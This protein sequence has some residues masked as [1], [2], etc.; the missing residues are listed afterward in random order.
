VAYFIFFERD[1]LIERRRS[2]VE[3]RSLVIG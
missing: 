1:G 3:R 2:M